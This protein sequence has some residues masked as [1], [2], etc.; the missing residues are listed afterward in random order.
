MLALFVL[1]LSSEKQHQNRNSQDIYPTTNKRITLQRDFLT[2]SKMA[3]ILELL[4]DGRWHTL[5]E[6]QERMK[7]G[8]P[9]LE[10]ITA[11]FKEY[12]F[13]V[14]DEE[15]KKIKLNKIAQEFL[16]QTTTA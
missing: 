10:R 14:N 9:Q 4:S 12:N 15:K 6:I 13:T 8:E 5:D 16:A 1:E 7:I 11:F 2:T 3:N